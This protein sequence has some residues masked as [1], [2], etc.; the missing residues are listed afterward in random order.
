[1]P[2][3]STR[4]GLA[5]KINVPPRSDRPTPAAKTGPGTR[6]PSKPASS[7]ISFQRRAGASEQAH[8]RTRAGGLQT[9]TQSSPL[10]RARSRHSL[11]S[12]FEPSS[13]RLRFAPVQI[14]VNGGTS[15]RCKSDRGNLPLP[16]RGST[17]FSDRN[18]ISRA[19]GWGPKDDLGG[20]RVASTTHGKSMRGD[21]SRP[22]ATYGSRCRPMPHSL[23]IDFLRARRR[24]SRFAP[25]DRNHQGL[26]NRLI[27]P[28]ETVGR[29]NGLVRC[30]KR[31]GGMLRYYY[32]DA[33]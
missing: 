1:M 16:P 10:C 12:A 14:Q 20:W 7:F 21:S 18:C 9:R 22:E 3:E 33:A 28:D 8:S 30:R 23:R 13:F 15:A 5:C 27:H 4:D 31:L 32:R 2:S 6:Q 26:G 29:S 25:K 24:S 19:H 17:E 11:R